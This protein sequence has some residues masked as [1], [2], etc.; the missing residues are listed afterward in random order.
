LDGGS[1]S[2]T[3]TSISSGRGSRLRFLLVV[4]VSSAMSPGMS[5]AD[6][7]SVPMAEVTSSG[8]DEVAFLLFF[9]FFSFLGFVL[10][11]ITDSIVVD[12]VTMACRY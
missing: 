4:G 3:S 10:V 8:A 5:S 9:S 6:S 12:I 1:G 11:S 7:G 2:A